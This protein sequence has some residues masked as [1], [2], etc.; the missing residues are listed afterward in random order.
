MDSRQTKDCLSRAKLYATKGNFSES[1]KYMLKGLMAICRNSSVLNRDIRTYVR[2]ILALYVKD[3]E[4]GPLCAPIKSKISG[5]NG[6]NERDLYV[7][8]KNVYDKIANQVDKEKYEDALARKMNL[9]KFMVKG[10]R[11]IKDKQYEKAIQ[12]FNEATNFYKD[13]SGFF[14]YIAK[15]F[16]EVEQSSAGILFLKKEL[17]VKPNNEVAKSMLLELTNKSK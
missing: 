17:E 15:L 3:P 16:I 8:L 9:D 5:Y 12:M 13:E 7:G 11:L 14:L 2:E 10:T 6:G 1:L 4:I